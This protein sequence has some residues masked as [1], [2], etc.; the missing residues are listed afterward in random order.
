MTEMFRTGIHDTIRNLPPS[1]SLGD[2]RDM[3]TRDYARAIRKHRV[4]PCARSLLHAHMSSLELDTVGARSSTPFGGVGAAGPGCLRQTSSLGTFR[5]RFSPPSSPLSTRRAFAGYSRGGRSRNNGGVSDGLDLEDGSGARGPCL[6]PGVERQALLRRELS[7]VQLAAATVAGVSS[8]PGGGGCCDTIPPP[9]GARTAASDASIEEGLHVSSRGLSQGGGGGRQSTRAQHGGGEGSAKASPRGV[10]LSDAELDR[11]HG[12]DEGKNERVDFPRSRKDDSE[13]K[14]IVGF[15]GGWNSCGD[16]K[17]GDADESA[18]RTNSRARGR[19]RGRPTGQGDG[20]ARPEDGRD[21]GP[22]AQPEPTLSC[23]NSRSRA[24][25]TAAA[26]ATRKPGSRRHPR[27]SA[28][29]PRH[30]K[31]PFSSDSLLS[32]LLDVRFGN[33]R[34][35]SPARPPGQKWD[36]RTI[37]AG[38]TAGVVSATADG[39]D[40]YDESE[41]L[42]GRASNDVAGTA[43]P[44]YGTRGSDFAVVC[45]GNGFGGGNGERERGG[46]REGPSSRA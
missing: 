30:L 37:P 9:V 21:D 16:V 38:I 4:D 5:S 41:D 32:C 23:Y 24:T 19:R 8:A 29:K 46:G 1:P 36:L 3:K 18:R 13:E 12:G 17:A 11:R 26:K 15:A 20:N 6:A 7:S 44:R 39:W 10:P 42:A 2:A 31:K 28:M 14:N 35:L 25:P 34:D 27:T 33:T 40:G 22:L 43:D 45:G